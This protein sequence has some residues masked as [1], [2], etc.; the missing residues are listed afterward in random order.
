M[1]FA[2]VAFEAAQLVDT[3]ELEAVAFTTARWNEVV[4]RQVV[5]RTLRPT[6]LLTFLQQ[7]EREGG[8][9]ARAS[10]PIATAWAFHEPLRRDSLRP[11]DT[12]DKGNPLALTLVEILAGTFLMGSPPEEPERFDDE[13]PQHEV[14]LESF[15]MGQTPIT[16]AQWREVAG[17]Q[18]RPGERWG[19]EL[20]ADPSHFQS[21]DGQEENKVRLLEGESNT[22]QRPVEQVSWLE[23]MEFCSRL[24]QRT[25][26]TY[27]LP[28]EAQWEYAC[29][30]GTT[31]PFHFGDTISPELA[32]YNGDYVYFDGPKG[33]NREQTTPV[34]GVGQFPANAWGLQDM[35]GNVWEWCL[36]EWHE[37]YEGAPTDGRAW[38]DGEEGEK[39][40]ETEK[41][42]LLRGGSWLSYPGLCRS[43]FRSLGGPGGADDGVGF[44]VVCLPQGP[45]LNP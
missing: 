12:T 20:S 8:A 7:V 44:R 2:E 22:D 23:A 17:W 37:S 32:N 34:L 9:A 28:S 40:S 42:S 3:P 6:D 21:K 31:T 29:R 19:R 18:E 13:G 5:F 43:A 33:I 26:R 38:V 15:F 14:T 25:G 11:G 36:D 16:Q 10:L 4:L 24:S 35:H 45:S 41:R 39:S 1:A 30:A 27:T